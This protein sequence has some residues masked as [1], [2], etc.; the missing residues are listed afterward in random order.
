MFHVRGVFRIFFKEEHQSSSLFKH[1]FFPG[2]LTL[3]NSS[4]KNDSRG[5]RDMLPRK[6]FENLHT[7]KAIV[8]LFEQLSGGKV[9]TYFWPLTLSASPNMPMIHFVCSV[10]IMRA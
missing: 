3:S 7:V 1:S 6:C 10:L 2:E 8:V 4:N 5:S 9:C